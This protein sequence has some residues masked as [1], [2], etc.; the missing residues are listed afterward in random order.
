MKPRQAP[1]LTVRSAGGTAY[2]GAATI[3]AATIVTP[4]KTPSSH[5]AGTS[6]EDVAARLGDRLRVLRHARNMSQTDL[7]VL[8]GVTA[9]Q[10]HRYERSKSAI[11]AVM[12]WRVATA[13]RE[14]VEYF[15]KDLN[16]TSTPVPSTR[17]R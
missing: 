16:Q 8:I 7:A 3:G 15:F 6:A 10:V 4:V 1:G 2:P 12:L 17:G 5:E 9:Q 14:P 11:T 13:L